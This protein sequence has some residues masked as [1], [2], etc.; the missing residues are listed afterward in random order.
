MPST[1]ES[2]VKILP[3]PQG[4]QCAGT[5]PGVGMPVNTA[6]GDQLSVGVMLS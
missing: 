3:V 6:L 1:P 4:Y 5:L 2:G